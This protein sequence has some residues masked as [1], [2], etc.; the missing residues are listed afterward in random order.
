MGVAPATRKDR[1]GGELERGCARVLV[2]LLRGRRHRPQHPPK[3]G[4][5]SARVPRNPR[6]D[7]AFPVQVVPGMRCPSS[8]GISHVS[9][10]ASC[11]SIANAWGD[12]SEG[13]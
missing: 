8:T 9:A 11:T 6:Q 1:E 3:V 4:S 2:W 13:G 10:G 5:A 7:T 12:P